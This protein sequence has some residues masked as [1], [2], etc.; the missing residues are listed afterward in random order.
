MFLQGST[1]SGD[2]GGCAT[3]CVWRVLSS[4]ASKERA[5]LVQ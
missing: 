2:E 1:R 5:V 3:G 4:G